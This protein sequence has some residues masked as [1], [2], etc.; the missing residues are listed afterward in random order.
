MGLVARIY[1]SID[2]FGQGRDDARMP[3][4]LTLVL[5]SLVWLVPLTFLIRALVGN[6]RRT[7]KFIE[8]NGLPSH[9]EDEALVQAIL[10]RTYRSP[11][12]GGLLGLAGGA[13]TS[14]TAN[15]VASSLGYVP[16]KISKF[17]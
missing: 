17:R 7:P 2:I 15:I 12:V 3:M 8:V 1:Q 13:L 4:S 11:F 14:A 5:V 6:R 10:R 9:P 16:T